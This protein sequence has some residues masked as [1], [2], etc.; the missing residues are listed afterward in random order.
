MSNIVSFPKPVEQ[1]VADAADEL[2]KLVMHRAFVVA[3]EFNSPLNSKDHGR[4]LAFMFEAIRS[5]FLAA[6]DRSHVLQHF[7][8]NIYRDLD[9]DTD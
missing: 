2:T 7:A 9:D 6:E 8:Y 1:E 4:E 3:Q 5:A